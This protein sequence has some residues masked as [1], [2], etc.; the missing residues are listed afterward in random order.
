MNAV[1]AL[2]GRR[3]FGF[4]SLAVL[5][6]LG[7]LL[8][9]VVAISVISS[10]SKWSERRGVF[11]D[12]GY[13]R[14]AHLF[15]RFGFSGI[16][17]DLNRDDDNYFKDAATA[18]RSIEWND[19]NVPFAHTFVSKTGKTV[20]QYPPGTGA[21]LALFPEGRQVYGLYSVSCLIVLAIAITLIA[22]AT[23]EVQA[24]VCSLFGSA[25]VYFFVNPIKASYSVAPSA[26]MC[27]VL[28]GDHAHFV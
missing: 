1:L 9:I 22:S 14:Q 2:I 8:T 23:N 21:L 16:D 7:F 5:K 25:A 4:N 13:L 24:I 18:I 17:T 19:P 6:C 27:A 12:I 15:Q 28:G 11:D 3:K 10:A 20:I 26:A